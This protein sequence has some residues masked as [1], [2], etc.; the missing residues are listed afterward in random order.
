MSKEPQKEQVNPFAWLKQRGGDQKM[1]GIKALLSS[2]RN[3]ET[4]TRIPNVF[5]MSVLDLLGAWSSPKDELEPMKLGSEEI[6]FPKTV[7]GLSRYFGIR[8]RINAI[9]MEGRSREEYVAALASYLAQQQMMMQTAAEQRMTE[10]A[11]KKQ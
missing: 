6:R 2:D 4:K 10:G 5:G 8:Y 7:E 9:S 11:K 3:N 1:E